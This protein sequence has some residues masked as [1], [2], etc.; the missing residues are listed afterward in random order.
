MKGFP[1]PARQRKWISRGWGASKSLV[2]AYVRARF[3]VLARRAIQELSEEVQ[4][5]FITCYTVLR[6]SEHKK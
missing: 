1:P 4:S 6:S 3:T 2:G 5:S